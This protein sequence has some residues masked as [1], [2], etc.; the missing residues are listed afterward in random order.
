MTDRK[1][2]ERQPKRPEAEGERKSGAELGTGAFTGGGGLSP[3]KSE[4]PAGPDTDRH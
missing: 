3:G 2:D 4:R 1:Q